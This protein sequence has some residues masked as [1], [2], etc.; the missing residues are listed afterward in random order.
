MEKHLILKNIS[1]LFVTAEIIVDAIRRDEDNLSFEE[2]VNTGEF[3]LPKQKLVKELLQK[4]K[5]EDADFLNAVSVSMLRDFIEKYP[6]S[7][8]LKEVHLRIRSKEDEEQEKHRELIENIINNANDYRPDEV[9]ADLGSKLLSEV[10]D[11]LGISF[12]VVNNYSEPDL[13]FNDIPKNIGEIPEG[14]TDVFFWGIPSSGKTCALSAILTTMKD[15]YAMTSPAIDPKFGASYVVSL[16]NIFTNQTAYLPAATQK[17]STQYMPLLLK[18]RNENDYRK[19]SFFELSGE[20]FKHFMALENNISIL[21]DDD[22]VDVESAFKTL[23]LL[24]GSNNQKIH[25]FF[26]DYQYETKGTR[27]RHNLTQE[28]YLNA[29]ASYFRDRLDIFKRKTDAV[30]VIVTKA[31]QI[32]SL[33]T[34]N[35]NISNEER[36]KIA[37]DFLYDNFGNFMD[38]IK[39]RCKRD[40]IDFNVKT[41]SIGDVYFKSICKLNYYYATNIIEDLLKRID[42]VNENRFCNW[43]TKIFNS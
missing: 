19:V 14:F 22:R 32:K 24:L 33:D 28:N 42:T 12:D 39:N 17:D 13:I 18:K 35:Q 15:K 8:H 38:F 23:D 21:K 34:E 16:Q 41:F 31:D 20:V 11:K 25:F 26:I 5:K 30:Y 29:A 36:T 6:E 2:A 9:K 4:F 40:S 27:D 7:K 1:E 37:S 3:Q 10:C 43:I